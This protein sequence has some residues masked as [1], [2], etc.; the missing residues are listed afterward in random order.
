[1]ATKPKIATGTRTKAVIIGLI[2]INKNKEINAVRVPPI[3]CTRPVPTI[4]LTPSTSLII[5]ET[6]SPDLLL[7]KKFIG[8]P[9]TFSCTLTLNSAI[10]C[11]ASTLNILVNKNEVTA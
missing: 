1:M 10:K 2:F 6:N 8:K 9:K 4:F 5:R 3:S 7:S 11:C